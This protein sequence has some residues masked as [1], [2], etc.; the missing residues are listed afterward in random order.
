MRKL[1]VS[2]DEDAAAL[3]SELAGGPRKQGAF[4]AAAVRAEAHRRQAVADLPAE[5]ESLQRKVGTLEQRLM[6]IEQRS[7]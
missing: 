1:T 4:I 6:A 2:L 3:L 7:H 5:V